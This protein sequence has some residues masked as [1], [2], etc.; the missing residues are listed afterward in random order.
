MEYK[1]LVNEAVVYEIKFQYIFLIFQ[2]MLRS[3]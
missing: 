2:N 1:C 3:N